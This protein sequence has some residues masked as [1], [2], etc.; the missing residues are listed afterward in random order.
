M[1]CIFFIHVYYSL[2]FLLHGNIVALILIIFMLQIIYAKGLYMCLLCLSSVDASQETCL[3][4]V[5]NM[6]TLR[7][8]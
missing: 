1:V 2:I 8:L 4:A 5:V 6:S 7:I 3:G